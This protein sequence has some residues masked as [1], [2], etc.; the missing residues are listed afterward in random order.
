MRLCEREREREKER[1]DNFVCYQATP[2][3]ALKRVPKFSQQ[4]SHQTNPSFKAQPDI[5]LGFITFLILAMTSGDGTMVE[6][7]P[8]HP[9]VEGSRYPKI[10]DNMRKVLFRATSFSSS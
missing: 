8:H 10:G 7:S 4:R 5:E 2:F 9:K 1:E 3:T 6:H